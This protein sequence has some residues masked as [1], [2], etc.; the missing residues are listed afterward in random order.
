MNQLAQLREQIQTSDIQLKTQDRL[1]LQKE[2]D[3]VRI[4]REVKECQ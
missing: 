2:E 4:K 1:L 3:I